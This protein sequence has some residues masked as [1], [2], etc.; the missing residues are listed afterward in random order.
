M[1]YGTPSKKFSINEKLNEIFKVLE[2]K[3]CENNVGERVH[4]IE[5]SGSLHT[6]Y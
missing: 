4:C 1:L 2:M 6:H 5:T 3:N